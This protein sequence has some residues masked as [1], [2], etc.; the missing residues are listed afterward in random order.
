MNTRP[1]ATL[2]TI[3]ETGHESEPY[4]AETG[5]SSRGSGENAEEMGQGGRGMGDDAVYGHVQHVQDYNGAENTVAGPQGDT[6]EPLGLCPQGTEGRW[7]CGLWL[8][9]FEGRVWACWT[10]SGSK[11]Y[12]G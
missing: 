8:L 2:H 7:L 12:R 3:P 4:N 1:P 11:T 6:A 9:N 10:C 5:M